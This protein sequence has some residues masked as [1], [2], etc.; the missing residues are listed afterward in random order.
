MGKSGKIEKIKI[1]FRTLNVLVGE[2]LLEDE[3]A[4][5]YIGRGLYIEDMHYLDNGPSCKILLLFQIVQLLF[6]TMIFIIFSVLDA[7]V[8]CFV[9]PASIRT[10]VVL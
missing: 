4:V 6:L 8:N 7:R 2:G 10:K 3:E 1:D 9:R 5:K